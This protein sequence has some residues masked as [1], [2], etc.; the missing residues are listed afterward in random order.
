MLRIQITAIAALLLTSCG[1]PCDICKEDAALWEAC[2]E[3]WDQ[4]HGT[5]LLCAQGVS[6]DWYDGYGDLTDAGR[7]EWDASL[8]S[9]ESYRMVLNSCRDQ[10]RAKERAYDNVDE[11]YS[12]CEASE[13]G[14]V[15]EAR[16]NQD[17]TGWLEAVGFI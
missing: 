11:Y 8:V 12:A 5:E 3:E 6:P 16:R 4:E 13:D 2:H 9:C 14:A 10:V 7:E 17:C 1:N 15:A